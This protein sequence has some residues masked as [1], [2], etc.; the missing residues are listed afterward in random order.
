MQG[1]I[2][3]PAPAPAAGSLLRA[4]NSIL[5]AVPIEGPEGNSTQLVW[6]ADRWL[7][8]PPGGGRGLKSQDF[9]YWAPLVWNDTTVPPTVA[10]LTW[11]A[12]FELNVAAA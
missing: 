3:P 8:A 1:Y 4:Q 9:Q 10:A 12:G 5:I 2:D 11:T 6:A 7:S